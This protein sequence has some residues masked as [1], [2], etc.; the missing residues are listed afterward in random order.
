[1][2]NELFYSNLGLE[3]ENE[4]VDL[5]N[6]YSIEKSKQI[7]LLKKPLS[8]DKAYR[9]TKGAFLLQA[10]YKIIFIDFENNCTS[11]VFKDYV[12]DILDD[13]N[14]VCEKFKYSE[15][16]ERPRYWRDDLTI[17]LNLSEIIKYGIDYTFENNKVYI[18]TEKRNLELIISLLTGSINDIDRVKG[19]VPETLLEKIKKKIILFDGQQT[20]FLY[21]ENENKV[22]KIQGLAGTGKTEL[23]LHKLKTLYTKNQ[24]TKI[25]FT[26]YNRILHDTLMNRI[27]DFF[28]FMK[29]EE[30]IKWNERLWCSRGWG[31]KKNYNVGLYSFIC[32]HYKLKFYTYRDIPSFAVVCEEAI[33]SIKEKIEKDNDFE[34]FFDYILVDESQDFPKEFFELCKLV[35]KNTIYIAG[36]IFQNI[37]N[38]NIEKNIATDFLLNK[39]YRTDPNT[40]MFAHAV[41]MGLF[42][43]KRI[44]WLDKDSLELCGYSVNENKDNYILTR[45]PLKRFED[46]ETSGIKNIELIESNEKKYLIDILNIIERIKSDHPS[47]APDDIAIM[48]LKNGNNNYL[49]AS[50]LELLIQEKFGW[51][52][53]IGYESQKKIPK[54][55]MITNKNNI[56]GLEFPFVICLGD[57]ISNYIP[58]RNSIYMMLTRSFITSY[59]IVNT[60][61]TEL[62]SALK[63]GLSEILSSGKMTIKKATEK[64]QEIIENNILTYLKNGGKSLDELIIEQMK[65]QEIDFKFKKSI[66]DAIKAKFELDFYED[67]DIVDFISKY[68]TLLIGD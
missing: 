64:E 48:F 27:P 30:Q 14:Y 46:L 41:G 28:N 20:R 29:V 51:D 44:S 52:T 36:D 1:M 40:L 53:N 57:M 2:K 35:T 25:C 42:E 67:D 34:Q 59:L 56:K 21:Q 16:L 4:I 61:Q 11:N 45:Q 32:H 12:Y 24:D 60:E 23:L 38:T 54:T 63:S 6:S 8:I 31:E 5:L 22:I 43:K 58:D 10:D 55:L 66:E 17:S 9:Y 65:L 19:N 37:F 47:V 13:L 49:L 68:K 33:K 62:I 15:Q 39:C 50:Q 26:C 3:E 18:D 7:F